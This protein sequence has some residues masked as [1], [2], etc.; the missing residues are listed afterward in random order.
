MVVHAHMQRARVL[1]QYLLETKKA[2]SERRFSPCGIEICGTTLVL[3]LVA[4]KRTGM[5]SASN[6]QGIWPFPAQACPCLLL[7]VVP[8]LCH[9]G[10]RLS[11]DHKSTFVKTWLMVCASHQLRGCRAA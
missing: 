2:G 1:A 8:G 9:D 11:C 6:M 5:W 10:A 7:S 3:V 4:T